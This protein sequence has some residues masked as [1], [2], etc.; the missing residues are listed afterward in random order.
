V[1]KWT[2]QAGD[3]IKL[4]LDPRTGHEQAGWRPALV[5]SEGAYNRRAG[6]CLVCPITSHVKGYPFE[7]RLQDSGEITGVVL[8]DHVK[9][10]DFRARR[11]KRIG[12]APAEVVET[13]RRY[14]GLLI[15]AK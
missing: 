11:A 5:I 1:S 7:V 12:A 6:L 10:V 8:S 3:L 14:V 2:P 4:D 15:G 13:V 9:S